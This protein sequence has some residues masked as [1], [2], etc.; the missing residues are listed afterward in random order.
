MII[1]YCISKSCNLSSIFLWLDD[2]GPP[3]L[4][5]HPCHEMEFGHCLHMDVAFAVWTFHDLLLMVK[6]ACLDDFGKLVITMDDDVRN[7]FMV[8]DTLL[9]S[10]RDNL[11]IR[12]EMYT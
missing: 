3:A 8:E 5:H 2:G 6:R 11:R 4:P 10:G 12:R 7:R 1:L 9:A